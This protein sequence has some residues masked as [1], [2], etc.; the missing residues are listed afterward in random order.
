MRYLTSI[1]TIPLVWVVEEKG[2]GQVQGFVAENKLTRQNW[3]SVRRSKCM[4]ID[5]KC[6]NF[7]NVT[8]AELINSIIR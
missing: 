4:K 3:Y 2:C 1:V 8:L 5:K 6:E 7:A